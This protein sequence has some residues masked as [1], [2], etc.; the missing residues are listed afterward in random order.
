MKKNEIGLKIKITILISLV[1]IVI[2]LLIDF[3]NIFSIVFSKLNW[4]FLEI[5]INN[6][7]L[8]MIFVITYFLIDKRN[9]DKNEEKMNNQE[10]VLKQLLIETYTECRKTIELLDNNEVLSKYIVPK[11]DFNKTDFD[12][13]IVTNL[14]DSPFKNE[15]IILELFKE[16]IL[17]TVYLCNYLRIKKEY[18]SYISIRIAF[19]E[20]EELTKSRRLNLGQDLDLELNSL[21]D[22]D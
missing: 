3:S 8:I 20:S 18:Q 2:T 14:K 21:F 10:Y 6:V 15:N 1:L 22:D 12:N 13:F 4:T 9:M 5:I 11:V 17:L 7:I 19:F 16:G